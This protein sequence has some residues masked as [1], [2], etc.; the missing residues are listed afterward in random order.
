MLRLLSIAESNVGSNH[1][2]FLHLFLWLHRIQSTPVTSVFTISNSSGTFVFN[3]R[4]LSAEYLQGWN[5]KAVFMLKKVISSLEWVPDKQSQK[6]SVHHVSER[7]HGDL[8]AVIVPLT[9]CKEIWECDSNSYVNGSNDIILM[10]YH[11]LRAGFLS[12]T[13]SSCSPLRSSSL[14]WLRRIHHEDSAASDLESMGECS[15]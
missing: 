8:S 1:N 13:C 6:I 9:A 2:I 12:A 11:H 3:S 5:R 14:Q 15:V 4:R 7:Y 10:D